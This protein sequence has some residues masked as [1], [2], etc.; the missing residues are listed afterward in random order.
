LQNHDNPKP[1]FGG[2][3]SGAGIRKAFWDFFAQEQG[4]YGRRK[5]TLAC[6]LGIK[7]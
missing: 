4:K 1:R 3:L 7:L 2:Y 5:Q 6:I